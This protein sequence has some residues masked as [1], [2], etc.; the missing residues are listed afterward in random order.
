MLHF[1]S[2]GVALGPLIFAFYQK[3]LFVCLFVFKILCMYSAENTKV[4]G[5]ASRGIGALLNREPG[6]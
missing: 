5:V 2:P 6:T 3:F 1:S 4:G